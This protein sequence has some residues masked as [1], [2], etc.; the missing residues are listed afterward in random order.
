MDTSNNQPTEFVSGGP[1][2][3]SSKVIPSASAEC[4]SN[5]GASSGT[6]HTTSA[7]EDNEGL[8]SPDLAYVQNL[9]SNI[10]LPSTQNQLELAMKDTRAKAEC[11][12]HSEFKSYLKKV[13][14][15]KGILKHIFE[16][17]PLTDANIH[18]SLKM[19]LVTENIVGQLEWR[20]RQID[21]AVRLAGSGEKTNMS[22]EENS[23]LMRDGSS[24]L[25]EWENTQP[26][27][28]SLERHKELELLA[29]TP[30]PDP[31]EI[32]MLAD[33]IVLCVVR[34]LTL[35]TSADSLEEKAYRIS[36][37]QQISS[38]L[39]WEPLTAAV[40]S[41]ILSNISNVKSRENILQKSDS[42]ESNVAMFCSVDSYCP[43]HGRMRS[44]SPPVNILDLASQISK[45]I[46]SVLGE[47][48]IFQKGLSEGKPK[49]IY[50]PPPRLADFDYVYNRLVK[51]VAN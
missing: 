15:K 24:L 18:E 44:R 3:I 45:V 22:T 19:L 46:I 20:V 39:D 36:S 9:L 51:E 2:S 32:Q 5:E 38:C 41:N 26:F 1:E 29:C 33:H 16:Q 6:K 23:L 42:F 10:R 27:S 47:R 11:I 17:Q 35:L 13:L 25:S 34:E 43:E 4:I 30:M 37:S 48:N 14:P 31:C 21:K 8:E 40:I 12:S 49:Y 7:C 28:K 50:V